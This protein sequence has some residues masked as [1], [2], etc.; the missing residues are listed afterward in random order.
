M[1]RPDYSREQVEAWAPEVP[2]TAAGR[3]RLASR[4]TLVAEENG[5][6]VGFAELEEDGHLD[7]FYLREDAVGRGM[8]SILYRAIEGEA[9]SLGLTRIFTE[10]SITARPFFGRQGFRVIREQTV[11]RRGVGL[12]NFVMEK[13]LDP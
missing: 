13:S 5:E 7:M 3:R 6:V 2:D 1:N 11:W 9:R 10:S 4:K 8:G 12:T